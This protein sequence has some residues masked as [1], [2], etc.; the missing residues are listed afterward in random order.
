MQAIKEQSVNVVELK[1]APKLI[2]QATGIATFAQFFSSIGTTAIGTPRRAGG[3]A[4]DVPAR[5]APGVQRRVER[6][7]AE[8]GHGRGCQPAAGAPDEDERPWREWV[9]GTRDGTRAGYL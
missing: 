4:R 2:A 7:G 8:R 1:S 6:C 9:Y 5:V 3:A